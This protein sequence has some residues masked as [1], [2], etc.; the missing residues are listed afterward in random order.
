[1]LAEM[2]PDACFRSLH[3]DRRWEAFLRKMGFPE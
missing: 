1:V 3:A 2:K